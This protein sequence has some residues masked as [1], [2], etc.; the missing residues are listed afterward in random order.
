MTLFT[1]RNPVKCVNVFYIDLRLRY[2][3]LLILLVPI[4]MARC[5]S[6]I[7]YE[8]IWGY[9][10]K[11]ESPYN[12]TIKDLGVPVFPNTTSQTVR[13][14]LAYGEW[15]LIELENGFLK[16]VPVEPAVIP[17]GEDY[18]VIAQYFFNVSAKQTPV[19]SNEEALGLDEI[20]VELIGYTE[21]NELYPSDNEEIVELAAEITSGETSV[22]GKTMRMV[23]WFR[24]YSSYMVNEIPK[25]PGAMV[26][27]PRGDCDDLGLLF[28]SMCRSQ[29]IPAYLQGGVVF[30]ETLDLDMT[31]WD[32]HYRFIFDEAGW[33]A[34][35]MVYIPPWG[36][37]PVDLTMIDGMRPVEAITEAYYWRDSTVVMWNITSH[38][39]VLDDENQRQTFIENDIYWTE[40]NTWARKTEEKTP[41]QLWIGVVVVGA[42]LLVLMRKISSG[43]SP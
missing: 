9:E 35:V 3:L 13:M 14:E 11:G 39:Y 25:R 1:H 42:L 2:F 20:P 32:G 5:E 26:R 22:L 43:G 31:E 33:H 21:A 41:N 15:G 16:A 24:D 10:N 37:L 23:D 29:G 27:D 40:T 38:D 34:W 4:P 28:I 18:S 36:W 6:D 12:M 8:M 19:L 17:A 7:L 30:S